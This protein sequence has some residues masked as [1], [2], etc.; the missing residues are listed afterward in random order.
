MK[1]SLAP[2]TPV[3]RGLLASQSSLPSSWDQADAHGNNLPV[4]HLEKPYSSPVSSPTSKYT[5]PVA[6]GSDFVADPTSYAGRRNLAAT[7]SGGRA[8][9]LNGRSSG[10][11]H[12]DQMWKHPREMRIAEREAVDSFFRER[13]LDKELYPIIGAFNA[14]T[15]TAGQVAYSLG[16]LVGKPS[17]ARPSRASTSTRDQGPLVKSQ[18]VERRLAEAVRA[19]NAPA[20]ARIYSGRLAELNGDGKSPV[21]SLLRETGSPH[22]GGAD[23]SWLFSSRAASDDQF[24]KNMLLRL[25]EPYS[26]ASIPS[27]VGYAPPDLAK[28]APAVGDTPW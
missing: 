1:T 8:S 4:T 7:L 20:A 26:P 10:I 11:T 22:V 24:R 27:E 16:R 13:S 9:L 6:R 23:M 18:A 5:P 17:T 25:R 3:A 28:K 21:L 2:R 14:D 19:K 15:S 12:A